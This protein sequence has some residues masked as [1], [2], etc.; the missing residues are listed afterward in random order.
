MLIQAESEKTEQFRAAFFHVAPSMFLGAL[1]TVVFVIDDDPSMRAAIEDLVGSVA[2]GA[3]PFAS[4]QEFLAS[5]RPDAPGC[6]VLDVQTSRS[7]GA[8]H[9]QLQR[10]AGHFQ[11]LA[12]I[13][14]IG[15]RARCFRSHGYL[16]QVVGRSDRLI[17]SLRRLDTSL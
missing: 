12:C 2:L 14:D 10:A 16:R 5:K 15:I 7:L 13:A 11:F 4:P 8:L 9:L 1:D 17:V 3:R 6:L